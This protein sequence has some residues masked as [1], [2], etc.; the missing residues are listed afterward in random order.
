MRPNRHSPMKGRD[1]VNDVDTVY[2]DRRRAPGGI[3]QSTTLTRCT[4]TAAERRAYHP[5]DDDPLPV[6]WQHVH[7]SLSLALTFSFST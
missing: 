2:I 4:L 3:I 7:V 6:H 1:A 5:V